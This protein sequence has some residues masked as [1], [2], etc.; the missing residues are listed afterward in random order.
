MEKNI[1]CYEKW[2]AGL[3]LVINLIFINLDQYDYIKKICK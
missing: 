3:S 1:L 2:Y